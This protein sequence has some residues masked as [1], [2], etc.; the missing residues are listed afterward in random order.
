M[1]FEFKPYAKRF[2]NEVV[3]DIKFENFLEANAS[4]STLYLP[5]GKILW[6]KRNVLVGVKTV[7][8]VS[9][10]LELKTIWKPLKNCN[11]TPIRDCFEIG[12]VAVLAACLLYRSFW[13]LSCFCFRWPQMRDF[14]NQVFSVAV[15]GGFFSEKRLI[16]ITRVLV[17]TFI[18]WT[19]TCGNRFRT[20]FV[21]FTSAK[22]SSKWS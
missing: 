3:L 1:Y 22:Y 19:I 17:K 4:G 15:I 12:T 5:D 11:F 16:E 20:G 6:E 9:M 7:L 2:W 21:F 18:D 10:A 8:D 14:H 13:M